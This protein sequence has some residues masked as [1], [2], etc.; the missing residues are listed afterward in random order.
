MRE[1]KFRAW[2]KEENRM[3]YDTEIDSM[4]Y[5][6]W[7]TWTSVEIVNSQ[8]RSNLY[9]WMQYT[10][11]KDKN[12]KEIYE[13]DVVWDWNDIAWI[14]SYSEVRYDEDFS[15]FIVYTPWLITPLHEALE[16]GHWRDASTWKDISWVYVVSNI[17]E[18]PELL[19]DK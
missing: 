3:I 17:Y 19:T 9:E 18:N 10:W 7:V 12:E 16:N 5:W 2:D 14:D 15:W 11:L 8:L 1:I 13:G 4:N 6:D